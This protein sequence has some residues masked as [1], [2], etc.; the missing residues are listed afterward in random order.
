[1][2][3]VVPAIVIG[4]LE[5][6]FELGSRTEENRRP[7]LEF[8]DQDFVRTHNVDRYVARIYGSIMSDLRRRG[9]PIPVNDIWIAATTVAAQGRLLT[10][11]HDFEKIA[12]LKGSLI[13]LD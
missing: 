1:M 13:Q 9:T 3:I 2:I 5:M 11:D 6:A 12:G 10:F 8:L 7:F 4:E